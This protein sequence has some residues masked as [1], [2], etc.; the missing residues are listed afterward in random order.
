MSSKR[1]NNEQALACTIG[2]LV[3]MAG[4]RI[5]STKVSICLLRSD[6]IGL[7]HLSIMY[8][9][10][11]CPMSSCWFDLSCKETCSRNTKTG[12]LSYLKIVLI[13]SEAACLILSSG[14][15]N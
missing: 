3:S 13:S 2:L 5:F 10:D 14:S 1:D 12:S 15:L 6:M 4:M 11:S 9:R 8:K 7:M